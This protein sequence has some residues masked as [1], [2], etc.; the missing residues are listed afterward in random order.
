MKYDYEKASGS[1]SIT[2]GQ[3]SLMKHLSKKEKNVSTKCS[4][5]SKE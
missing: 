1:E 2:H 4:Q 5:K 3:Y